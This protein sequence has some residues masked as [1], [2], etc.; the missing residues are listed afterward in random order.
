MY[1]TLECNDSVNVLEMIFTT[2]VDNKLIH[3]F[4]LIIT[5]LHT[6]CGQIYEKGFYANI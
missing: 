4:D 2:S 1:H 5:I 3:N 6:V